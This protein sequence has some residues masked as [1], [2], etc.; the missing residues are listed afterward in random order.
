MALLIDNREE[1]VTIKER[2]EHSSITTTIDVYGHLFPNR[3]Q[4]MTD[5]LNDWL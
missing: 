5:R 1:L 4:E 2:M 3:Q